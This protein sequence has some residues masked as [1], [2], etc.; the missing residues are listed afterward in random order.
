MSKKVIICVGTRPNF[1][2]IIKLKKALAKMGVT[3]SLLHTGQHFDVNMSSIFFDQLKLD[4]PDFELNITGGDINQTTGKIIIKSSA[5]FQTDKPDMVVVVGDVNSTFA[6]AFAAAS[7]DIPVAHIESGLRSYRMSMPEERNRILTD[8]VSSL[9][10]VTE[11]IGV[12][13]LLKEGFNGDAIKLVGNTMVD[14]LVEMRPIIDACTLIEDIGVKPKEYGLCTFH[15]PIN[16]D[17]PDSLALILKVLSVISERITLVFPI[18]PRTRKNIEHFSLGHLL[19][20]T[21]GV[22]LIEPQGYI[23]FIHLIDNAKFLISDSG[24]VQTEASFLNVP[25]ITLRD[26]TEL[27]STIT[28]GTNVLCKLDSK[29]ILANFEAIMNGQFKAKTDV[30]IWDGHATERICEVIHDFLLK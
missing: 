2:K 18:H 30:E 15:R 29:A 10:F 19:K 14:A 16:V 22:Q 7:L 13:N 26:E 25:C 6:C 5:V 21:P 8:N 28:Y 27:E 3:S 9:L 12:K 20:N 23:E 1:I 4:K 17:H 11:E 24:G